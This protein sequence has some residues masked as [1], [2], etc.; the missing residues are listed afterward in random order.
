MNEEEIEKAIKLLKESVDNPK[1]YSKCCVYF[2]EYQMDKLKQLSYKLIEELQQEKEKNKKLEEVIDLMAEDIWKTD[3]YFT[4]K[5][6][7]MKEDCY[8][9]TL[10]DGNACGGNCIKQ[11]YFKKARGKEDVKDN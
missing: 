4:C 10:A 11:Y 8:A 2:D 3:D 1:I 5:D 7:K 6:I 9:D